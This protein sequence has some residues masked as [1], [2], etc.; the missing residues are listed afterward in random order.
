M[1]NKYVTHTQKTTTELQGPDLGQAHAPVCGGVKQ[2]SEIPT[3]Q[4]L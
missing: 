3:L 1:K 2:V 4:L